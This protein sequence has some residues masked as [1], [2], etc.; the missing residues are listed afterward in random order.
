VGGARFHLTFTSAA[1]I[2]AFLPQGGKAGALKASATNPTKSAAG[3]FA[4]Q[5]VALAISV[6]MSDAGV[7]RSNLANQKLTSGKL[8]GQTVRT[9]LQLCYAALNGDALPAG[10]KIAD[11]NSIADAIN[12]NFDNGT[13]D[14]GYLR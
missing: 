12:N 4:G 1:A 2:E 8:A 14:H 5:V 6:A 9:V 11:L 7:T 3:V 10:L 13:Q